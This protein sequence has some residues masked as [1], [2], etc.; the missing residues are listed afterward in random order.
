MKKGEKEETQCFAS[1]AHREVVAEMSHLLSAE[2][3]V[4][5]QAQAA[6]T[7]ARVGEFPK[8]DNASRIQTRRL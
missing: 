3:R 5:I 7:E 1:R 2:P 4:K 6:Q 8:R